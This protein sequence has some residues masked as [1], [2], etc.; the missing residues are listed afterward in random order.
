MNWL[1]PLTSATGKTAFFS[2]SFL[3]KYWYF[4]IIPLLLLPSVISSVRIAVETNN[5]TYPF[6]VLSKRLLIADN[7]LRQDV[8]ILE[9]NPQKLV[10]MAKP[11]E[12]IWNN[13][14]YYWKFFWNVIW[15]ILGN[16]YLIFFPLIIIYKLIKG[17]NISEPYK[18]IFRSIMF[19]LIYLFITNT[20]ILIHGIIKGDIIIE[21][22]GGLSVWK[23]YYA[24][25]I[26]TLPFHG[27][28]KLA[29]YI[30]KSLGQPQIILS[31]LKN[32]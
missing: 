27:M 14:K 30:T 5:P 9:S 11:S 29:I 17:R 21:L 28:V 15:K 24:I 26:Y 25:F 8:E 12:G 18:N 16:I 4:I 23:E 1:K 3:K 31:L 13:T 22:T 7:D 6:F 32:L 2:F 19:F 20:V 10:G